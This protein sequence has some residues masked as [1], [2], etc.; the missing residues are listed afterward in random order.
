MKHRSLPLHAANKFY[1]YQ[2]NTQTDREAERVDSNHKQLFFYL[3]L[4]TLH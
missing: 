1:E 3:F 2:P 4:E